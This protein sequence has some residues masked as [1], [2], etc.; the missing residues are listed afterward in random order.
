MILPSSAGPTWD[1][2]AGGGFGRDVAE[3]DRL[4]ATVR[5]GEVAAGPTVLG[6]S[7]DGAS[8]ALSLGLANGGLVDAVLAF[9]PGFATPPR[10]HGDPAVFIADGTHDRVLPVACSHRIL[11]AFRGHGIHPEYVEF[12]GGHEVPAAILR[13]ALAWSGTLAEGA[14]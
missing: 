3:L 14:S 2:I 7:S 11:A 1:L 10:L 5:T 4:I 9:S 13:D 6:G 8:Y 12:D